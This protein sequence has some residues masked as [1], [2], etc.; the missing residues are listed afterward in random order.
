MKQPKGKE[1]FS[2]I[3]HARVPLTSLINFGGKEYRAVDEK[4]DLL[5]FLQNTLIWNVITVK[6]LS[7]YF[8]DNTAN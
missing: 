7:I 6:K 2:F 8:L 4:D 1:S 5:L 3:A